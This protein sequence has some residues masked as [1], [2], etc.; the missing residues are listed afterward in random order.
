MSNV[1]ALLNNGFY[2]YIIGDSIDI[3]LDI[4]SRPSRALLANARE[5]SSTCVIDGTKGRPTRSIIVL[6]S[7]RYILSCIS[8][9]QLASRLLLNTDLNEDELIDTGIEV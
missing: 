1:N 3:I 2:Q 9:K 8:R 5:K 6:K 7:D 4:D